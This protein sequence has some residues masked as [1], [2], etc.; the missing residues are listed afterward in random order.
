MNWGDLDP[1]FSARDRRLLPYV[2]GV[3]VGVVLLRCILF[4]FETGVPA[5]SHYYGR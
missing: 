1:Q 5:L 2:L 4:A 3:Y